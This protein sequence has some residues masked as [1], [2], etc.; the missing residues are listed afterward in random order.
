MK[1]INK[2]NNKPIGELLKEAGLIN[3]GQLQ[4]ALV[5]KQLYPSLKLGEIV[6]LHGWLKQETADFFAEQIKNMDP[7]QKL[8]LGEYFCQAGLLTQQEIQQLK[9]E[10][11]K[12]GMKFSSIAVDAGLVKQKTIDFFLNNFILEQKNKKA[13]RV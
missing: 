2:I 12:S 10:Q 6:S 9:I 8:S 11:R 5:E 1:T 4:V 7:H 13:F 3:T